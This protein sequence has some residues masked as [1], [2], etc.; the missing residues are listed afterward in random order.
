MRMLQS[1]MMSVLMTATAGCQSKD[2]TECIHFADGQEAI[3]ML[4]TEDAFTEKWSAF[5]IQSRMHD[6]SATRKDLFGFIAGQVIPWS[7]PEKQLVTEVIQKT[8][9]TLAD[10]HMNIPWPDDIYFIITTAEEEGGA[11]GYTRS[12]YIVLKQELISGLSQD[13]AHTITHELFHVLSRNNPELRKKLYSLIGFEVGPELTYPESLKDRRITNPDA[14]QSDSYITLQKDGQN[15]RCQMILYANKPYE[16]GSFFQYLKPGFL[17]VEG[18]QP[19][20][21][22]QEG[23]PL[24][25]SLNDVS[26]FFEQV[27]NNTQ[28]IIHPEEILADNFS[29]MITGEANM[30][31]AWL[32]EKMKKVFQE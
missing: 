22:M 20:A 8:Q 4:T 29:L 31:S 6:P 1:A 15:I 7:D 21:V 16:G 24:I 30:P 11:G 25:Y 14:P 18:D 3:R 9:Q 23:A 32:P 5:D 28:Y 10:N 27:G 19:H 2:L 13:V 26:G 12:N 17:V